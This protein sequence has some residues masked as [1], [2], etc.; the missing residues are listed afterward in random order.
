VLLGLR[1][2]N[3]TLG[4]R[5]L[6]DD[7]SAQIH[8]AERVGLVGPNGSGKTSLLR[9]VTGEIEPDSGQIIVPHGV[10]MGYLPQ[11]LRALE[12]TR[13]LDYVMSHAP[14]R[15]G[16]EERLAEIHQELAELDAMPADTARHERL[17]AASADLAEVQGHLDHFAIE[18]AEHVASRILD[19][20]GFAPDDAGRDVATLSGGWQMRAALAGLLFSRPEMLLL[21]EPTNHLDL[22]T[23]A[24]F[25]QFLRS[26]AGG[27]ILISHDREFL[28]G[29]IGRVLALTPEGL[30]SY[31]GNY[32]DYVR[33]RAVEEEFLAGR[34]KNLAREREK[35]EAFITR[36]RAQA[37]K[38]RAVQS[39]I[40]AVER[41]EKVETRGTDRTVA[42]HFV[43]GAPSAKRVLT[44]TGLHK[45]F[46]ER[47]VLRGVD[48]TAE[49]GERIAITGVNGAGKTTLLKLL[50]G[51]LAPNAGTIEWGHNVQV[52]YYAQH[53]SETL[54][55]G[56]TVLE[57]VAAASP[58]RPTPQV[59]NL[60]GALLFSDDSVDKPVSVLSGGERARVALARLLI[61]P[62]NVLLLDEPTN[63]LDLASSEQLVEA[64]STF[65]GTL[66]TVS[67]NL[68]FVRRLA[69]RIWNLSA[70]EI[71]T[72]PGTFDEYLASTVRR[73][74]LFETAATPEGVAQLTTRDKPTDKER[75]RSE[76]ELRSRR[77]SVLGPFE[78]AVVEIEEKIS[79]LE[80]EQKQRE[81]LMAEP[82]FYADVDR[83][84]EMGRLYEQGRRELASL[85]EIWEQRAQELAR[86]EQKFAASEC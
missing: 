26:F 82:G 44:V 18:F 62:A 9:L 36:F 3:L 39:R 25:A 16:L 71:E 4:G 47:P 23:V 29:Q 48:L 85:T 59:R 60:L 46:G 83:S 86:K 7:A 56:S 73:F 65:D 75:K 58:S 34:Q 27:L 67:H 54:P 57:A 1:S 22:P 76:A 38:A 42:F 20:L 61:V 53:H 35:A 72:Y 74:A 40:K 80:S 17:L 49:R 64:L 63:H 69:T 84:S 43:A 55:V 45:S 24:W 28:N 8:A 51:E 15:T 52:G 50:G 19:G 37:T 10:R 30:R 70:G 66:V 33:Q 79:A 14:G 78:R 41:M 2:I 5:T 12:S 31:T 6:F 21:D 68:G 11:D 13:L 32:E 77:R 81:E